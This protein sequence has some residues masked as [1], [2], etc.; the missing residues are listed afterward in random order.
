MERK[1]EDDEWQETGNIDTPSDTNADL[2]A[3]AERISEKIRERGGVATIYDIAELAEV[4]PST[5]S[6]ALGKPGRISAVT[7][8]K[9]EDAAARLGFRLNPMARALQTGKTQMLGLLVADIT[10]PVM[11]DVLR[12]AEQEAAAAGYTLV[13]ANSQESGT[14]ENAAVERLLSSV[15]GIVLATSRMPTPQVVDLARRK[16][17]VLMN[18]AVEG[19]ASVLPDVESGVNQLVTHLYDAGHR[20]LVYLEG[21][22]S[23]WI[24]ARR[25]EAILNA[26]E[27]LNIAVVAVGP[28]A[29]TIA[30][31]RTTLRQVMASHATAV[32][33]YN[34]LMA[35]GFMQEASA[36]QIS[37]PD[38]LSVTGFDNIFG[39]ELVVPAL[40]T[41]GTDL[42][43]A[44]RQAV[45]MT[46]AAINSDESPGKRA[47]GLMP[48]NLFIRGSSGT[49][50]R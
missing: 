23:S 16:P 13:I 18:R 36:N 5:V 11:F 42:V 14:K 43:Q 2:D 45:A 34:A 9:V 50:P 10:N 48:T 37:I 49:A 4:N 26:A 40:T 27:R 38:R 28:N 12:G 6:R 29:P 17:L 19:V 20:S 46:L 15:D 39:T 44:G 25:W 7:A 1:H 3:A 22:S 47:S 30:G 33:A 35:I 32:I 31:G 41:V 8:K 24:N 21:P